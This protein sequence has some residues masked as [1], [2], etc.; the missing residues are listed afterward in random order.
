MNTNNKIYIII[1]SSYLHKTRT[2]IT[3]VVKIV[4]LLITRN[5]NFVIGN[6]VDKKKIVL[7]Q[8]SVVTVLEMWYQ[9]LNK[10]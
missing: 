3:Q 6:L 8:E 10:S 9:R 7:R 5:N 2:Q 1:K 4:S